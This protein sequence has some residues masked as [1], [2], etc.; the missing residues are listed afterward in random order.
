MAELTD[1]ERRQLDPVVDALMAW[2]GDGTQAWNDL[3]TGVE[4]I[5]TTREAAAEHR[6]AVNALREAANAV[7]TEPKWIEIFSRSIAPYLRKKFAEW[8][9]SRADRIEAGD[10]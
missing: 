9:T 6:G 3:I 8:L 5:L 4:C 7:N 2:R 10:A 1:E